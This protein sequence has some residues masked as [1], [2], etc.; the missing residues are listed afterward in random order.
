MLGTATFTNETD[1]GWQEATFPTP[2]VIT[3]NTNYI[4][5]YHAPSGH[6]SLTTG[7]LSSEVFNQPLRALAN[8]DVSPGNGIFTYGPTGSF[9]N[10]TD[11]SSNYWVDV[12]FSSD[13]TP[14]TVNA[15]TPANNAIDVNVHT[16]LTAVFSEELLSSTV[17]PDTFELHDPDQNLI[18]ASVTYANGLLTAILDPT[19]W[20][21]ASTTYTVRIKGG[22]VDPV[23]E[24]LAGNHLAAD[25]TWSFTTAPDAIPPTISAVSPKNLVIGVNKYAS[26]IAHFSEEIDPS[27]ITANTF[28]LRDANN[29]NVSASISYINSSLTAI[30]DPT[31]LL[32]NSTTYTAQIMGG[33]PRIKDLAGNPLAANYIWTFTTAA[34]PAVGAEARCRSFLILE[35]RTDFIT[36]KSSAAEGF[37]EFAVVNISGVTSEMLLSYDVVLL[38]QMSLT[39]DQVTMFTN[40][41]TAG[42]N[43]IAMHPDKQLAGLLGLTDALGYPLPASC[44]PI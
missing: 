9:P 27:T 12:V 22:E 34:P 33:Q 24:D 30:L 32:S 26:V 5:S 40:W 44:T 17:S 38:G 28:Y 14:P 20:L 7:G 16:N 21:A 4:A 39:S 37:N 36:L 2:I 15:V 29:N 10:Y 19:S 13:I 3:A 43:L 25:F 18:P 1:S 23:I 6:W 11:G 41:V 8:G 35:I 31:S 42:G